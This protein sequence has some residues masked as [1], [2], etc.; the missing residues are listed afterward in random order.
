M[1]A[2]WLQGLP[3]IEHAPKRKPRTSLRAR[4][5]NLLGLDFPPLAAT[6]GTVPKEPSS[7]AVNDEAVDGE[8][9]NTPLL[10]A[11]TFTRAA[12]HQTLG[13]APRTAGAALLP[14]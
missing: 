9:A 3:R 6:C 14:Y 11:G 10:A 7:E 1:R 5:F 2:R 8:A 4:L 13:R 12:G